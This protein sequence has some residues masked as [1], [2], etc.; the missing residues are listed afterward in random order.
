M[1]N[2]ERAGR[3]RSCWSMVIALLMCALFMG[4]VSVR[5]QTTPTP[6]T[7]GENKTGAITDGSGSIQYTL[8]VSAPQSVT[9]QVLS[10]SPNFAPFFQVF[11]SDGI[12]VL[13][14]VNND[15]PT[16]AQS[17]LNI[18]SL[19]SYTIA[20]KS[21]ADTPGQFLIS[22]EAGA[23]LTPSQPLMLGQPVSGTV[24]KQTTRQAY[25]FSGS[26][27]DRLL[28]IARDESNEL[29]MLFT[30][31]D[32]ST[33]E[34]ISLTTAGLQ[35]LT[36]VVPELTRTY[37]LEITYVGSGAAQPF[38]V[39]LA[40]ESGSTP[41]SGGVEA[42][43]VVDA[44]AAPTQIAGVPSQTPIFAPAAINPGGACEVT[45]A[46]NNSVNIRSGA[47]TGFPI[48]ANL[49]A[50]ATGL[51]VGRLAD[52]S[53]Y[54]VNINGALGWVSA[55]V[56]IPGGNCAGV[57]VVIL[58]TA[59]PPTAV[60]PSAPDISGG[61]GNPAPDTSNQAAQFPPNT[62][63]VSGKARNGEVSLNQDFGT[64]PY[65][66]QI[67]VRDQVY[68]NDAL[69]SNCFGFTNT[70]PNFRL[71]YSGISGAGDLL[72]FFFIS[73]GDAVDAAMFVRDP[74]GNF[75][76][77]EDSFDTDNPTVDFTPSQVTSGDYEVWIANTYSGPN[78]TSNNFSGYLYISNFFLDHP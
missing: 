70:A 16:I 5:A 66:A 72:R 33:N 22:L 24:D 54:Q 19:G 40:S 63:N 39:C 18:S 61:S 3:R 69:G 35:G 30:L 25:W 76:C 45:P 59:I 36:Y 10:L 17:S 38:S 27:D 8:T 14:V 1:T 48:V 75:H 55:G 53:W 58:P 47:G 32:A 15:P 64:I 51:V 26:I 2:S 4:A 11:D 13:A 42:T 34:L 46:R 68:V 44:T 9:I 67:D 60:P 65:S 57:A 20:V 31:R 23:P 21:A 62:L 43:T 73:D 28:L 7:I 29:G 78:G 50:A 37:R 71:H 49:P 77:N 56:V 6:I 41:C 74:D 52:N 12:L